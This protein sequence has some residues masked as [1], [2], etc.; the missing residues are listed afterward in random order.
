MRLPSDS[1]DQRVFDPVRRTLPL[2]MAAVAVLSLSCPLAVG[3]PQE[4]ASSPYAPMARS[5][6]ELD[7]FR[8]I[9]LE[10]LSRLRLPLITTFLESF[11]RSELRYLVARNRWRA[12]VDSRRNPEDVI[13][14]AEE[15]LDSANEFLGG[16][17]ASRPPGAG[18][19]T[20]RPSRLSA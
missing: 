13:L 6:A 3:Q 16:R 7:A 8:A 11:P 9:E 19:R 1:S 17:L 2:L 14:A 18:S 20:P 15:A 5:A 10:T 4:L 12:F